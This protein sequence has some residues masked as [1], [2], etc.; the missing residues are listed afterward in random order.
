[1]TQAE[2]VKKL[3]GGL[4]ALSSA[5][6]HKH[7]TTVQGWLERGRIPYWRHDQIRKAGRKRKIPP[8]KVEKALRSAA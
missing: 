7:P 1:M 5:C 3:F 2:R 4:T 8:D 6:G